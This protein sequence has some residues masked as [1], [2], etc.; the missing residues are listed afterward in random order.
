M[1]IKTLTLQ[2]Y[3]SYH[4]LNLELGRL[5]VL[6]GPNG[7]GK[8][9]FLGFFRMLQRASEGGLQGYIDKEI[10]RFGY[11]GHLNANPNQAVS[12]RIAFEQADSLA[13]ARVAQG[14]QAGQLTYEVILQPV[15]ERGYLIGRE[16]LRRPPYPNHTDPYS[17]MLAERGVMRRLS[18][19]R[20]AEDDKTVP[21]SLDTDTELAITQLRDSQRYPSLNELRRTL[22]EWQVLRGFGS[23]A[24][25]AMRQ[26]QALQIQRVLRLDELASNLAPI[27]NQLKNTLTYKKQWQQLEQ[28][29]SAAF[30]DFESLDIPLT[31]GN[32]A[33]LHYRSKDLEQQVPAHL[34]SDGQLRFIGLVVTLLQPNPP[35]LIAIDEPE[36]GLHPQMLPLLAELLQDASK[37]TQLIIATHSNLLLSQL[38]PEQVLVTTRDTGASHIKRLDGGALEKWL[39]RYTLGQLW[40]SGRLEA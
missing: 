5:N 25:K 38:S 18:V 7:S 22:S 6:I 12:W 24:L 36:V 1:Y 15:L 3:R 26:P 33:M 14:Y 23:D 32:S 16:H 11:L 40:E 4:E 10:G 20:E 28:T 27:L 8:S 29:L 17:L 34:M 19:T 35:A 30:D 21:F 2:N 39:S 37:R 13:D 31:E 9:N